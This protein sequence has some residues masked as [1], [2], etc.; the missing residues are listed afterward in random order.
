MGGAEFDSFEA[1][2][3]TVFKHG[4]KIP[5]FAPIVSDQAEPHRWCGFGGCG[6]GRPGSCGGEDSG[7]GFKEV[8]SGG[9]IHIVALVRKEG[10]TMIAKRL[11]CKRLG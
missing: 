8:T 4:G 6:E 3:F 1:G 10:V 7:G 5:L 2:G 9:G 11:R